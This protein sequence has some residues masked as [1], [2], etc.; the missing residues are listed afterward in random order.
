MIGMNKRALILIISIL[1]IIDI[2]FLLYLLNFSNAA[3]DENFYKKEFQKYDV[4]GN[5]KNYDI[6][7]INNDVLDYLKYEKNK[8]LIE[9]DFFN[10]REKLHLLDVKNLIQKTVELYYF[11]MSL[12][13][14]LLVSLVFLL[15]KNIKI[16]KHLGI[17]FLIAGF[18]TIL[19]TFIFYI[20]INSNFSFA[21]D[22]FHNA[23]FEQGSFLFDSSS[24]NIVNLYPNG[25]F[26]DIARRIAINTLIFSSLVFLTG[27]LFLATIKYKTLKIRKLKKSRIIKYNKKLFKLQ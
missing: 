1:L 2:P 12:F 18:L 11:L 14:I 24:E 17:I 19:D 20:A 13:F 16:V 6:E 5:L 25:L 15:N 3:F 27:A 21:F 23:F 9:N 8:K 26:F 4:Y 22:I 7:K 10:E